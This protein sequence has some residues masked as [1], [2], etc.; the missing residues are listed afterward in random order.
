MNS[1]WLPA[2]NP[3]TLLILRS[4]RLAAIPPEGFDFFAVKLILGEILL[5]ECS[6]FYWSSSLLKSVYYWKSC[7]R[8][9]DLLFC[10]VKAKSLLGCS[11][12]RVWTHISVTTISICFYLEELSTLSNF[13]PSLN[14]FISSSRLSKEYS[15]IICLFSFSF[16]DLN[17]S[18]KLFFN[19]WCIF[20]GLS[21]FVS[22]TSSAFWII[23]VFL[24]KL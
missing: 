23:G 15:S 13:C 3:G 5:N 21:T 7:L 10:L 11:S 22:I 8:G 12:L 9:F 18:T 6:L 24:L 17:S 19:Y 16:F 1:S 4:F 2:L 14:W 20:I